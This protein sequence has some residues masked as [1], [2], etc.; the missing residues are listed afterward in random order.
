MT[1]AARV[2]RRLVVERRASA[3]CSMPVSNVLDLARVARVVF[4]ITL[5]IY[6]PRGA[7]QRRLF[8]GW[9][10]PWPSFSVVVFEICGLL[11]RQGARR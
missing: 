5:F 4:S 2:P 9:P 7:A 6:A 1:R 10:Q 3:A 11:I 8:C